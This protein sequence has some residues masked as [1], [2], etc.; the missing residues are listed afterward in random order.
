MTIFRPVSFKFLELQF[1]QS[2]LYLASCIF[3]FFSVATPYLCHLFSLTGKVL[4]PLYFFTILAAYKFGWKAGMF[5]A[6]LS[7]I[8]SYL[9]SGMPNGHILILVVLKGVALGVFAGFIAKKV[10]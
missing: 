5:T 2:R 3:V 7:P 8:I 4:L 6:L 9:L 1:T 10:N